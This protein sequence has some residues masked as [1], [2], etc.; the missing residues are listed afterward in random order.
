MNQEPSNPLAD[1]HYVGVLQ[2]IQAI[3]LWMNATNLELFLADTESLLK[4]TI[5]KQDTELVVRCVKK[6]LELRPILAEMNKRGEEQK[7]DIIKSPYN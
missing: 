2:R 3:V 6:L 5:N 7:K 4:N 1:P